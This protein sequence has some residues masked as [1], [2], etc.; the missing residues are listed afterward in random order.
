MPAVANSVQPLSPDSIKNRKIRVLKISK[1]PRLAYWA[2]NSYFLLSLISPRNSKLAYK[3]QVFSSFGKMTKA[4]SRGR[5]VQIKY[6][7][8]G[9]ICCRNLIHFFTFAK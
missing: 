9:K 5:P 6:E 8:L 1:K 3:G 4:C 7:N 2:G